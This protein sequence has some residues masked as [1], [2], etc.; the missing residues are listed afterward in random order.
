MSGS[1]GASAGSTDIIRRI[2][3]GEADDNL[4]G[5]FGAVQE[6]QKSVRSGKAAVMRHTVRPKQ[7][8]RLTAP[9]RK[10][11]VGQIVEIVDVN[12]SRAV[13]RFAR[14]FDAGKYAGSSSVT[15]PLDCMEPTDEPMPKDEWEPE[16]DALYRQAASGGRRSRRGF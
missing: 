15:V 1:N 14:T 4:S 11:L 2:I 6:R 5:V 16:V 8:V 13:V 12:K 9:L 3:A 10:W 7:R